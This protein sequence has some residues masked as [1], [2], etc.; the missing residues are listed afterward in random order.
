MAIYCHFYFISSSEESIKTIV[1]HIKDL[2]NILH[3][4]FYVE[5]I[6]VREIIL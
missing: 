4:V 3:K 5:E 1:Y 6:Y 2:E